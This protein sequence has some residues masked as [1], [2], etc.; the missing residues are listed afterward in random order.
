[1][2]GYGVIVEEYKQIKTEELGKK[3]ASVPLYPP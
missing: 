3:S 2:K 1:M